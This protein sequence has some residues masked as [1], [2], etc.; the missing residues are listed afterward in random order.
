SPLFI[1]LSHNLILL[2]LYLFQPSSFI[3]APLY[4]YLIFQKVRDSLPLICF[5]GTSF[6]VVAFV[7]F[8]V[9]FIILSL[10]RSL[11]S[12]FMFFSSQLFISSYSISFY[13]YLIPLLLSI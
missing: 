13:H 7:I 1:C 10:R 5:S 6:F 4:I 12:S 2:V 9:F 3:P 8:V 11:F